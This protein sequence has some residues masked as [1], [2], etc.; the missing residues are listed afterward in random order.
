MRKVQNATGSHIC[1]LVL[2]LTPAFNMQQY[3][4][5]LRPKVSELVNNDLV[6]LISD[7]LFYFWSYHLLYNKKLFEYPSLFVF[8]GIN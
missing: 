6:W 7:L 3:E 8:Y 4:C 5:N 1:S 2:Y